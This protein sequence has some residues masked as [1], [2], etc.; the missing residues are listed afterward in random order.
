VESC[1]DYFDLDTVIDDLKTMATLWQSS[2]L[3]YEKALTDASSITKA[4]SLHRFE[5]LSCA[6]MIGLQLH[7]SWNMFRFYRWR[8]QV[9]KAAG[10]NAPCTVTLDEQGAVIIKDELANVKLCLELTH[11][12]A[13]LGYHQEPQFSFYDS[14]QLEAKCKQLEALYPSGMI[15]TALK[16]LWSP[17]TSCRV[18]KQ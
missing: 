7:S 8:K 14:P 10:L 1:L 3:A 11:V 4:Q 16:M 17:K 13:R 5:E 2:L 18:Q 6:K 15:L 12:D 9:M